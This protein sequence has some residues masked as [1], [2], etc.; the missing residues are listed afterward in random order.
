MHTDTRKAASGIHRMPGLS[1]VAA[2][3]AAWTAPAAGQE[4]LAKKVQEMQAQ[5][6]EMKTRLDDMQQKKVSQEEVLKLMEK[7]SADSAKRASNLPKW[8]ENLKIYGDLRLRC[9]TQTY[10]WGN[11]AREDDLKSRNRA[12]FRLRV[13]ATKTWL[14]DQLEV[15]FRLASGNN[16]DPTATNQTLGESGTGEPAFAKRPVWIDLA[17]GKYAPNWAKGLSVTGGKMNNPLLLNE[18][19]MDTDI[20]PEGF[21]AEYKVPGL[22]PVEP[23]VGGGYFIL[24]EVGQTTGSVPAFDTTMWAYQGGVSWKIMEDLKYTVSATYMDYDY[25]DLTGLPTRGNDV[26]TNVHNF[27]VVN[28][29]NKVDFNVWKVPVCLFFDWAHNADDED[30]TSDYRNADDAYATGVQ[31]GQNKKQGDLSCK[32]RYFQVQGNSLPGYLVDGD[33]GQANHQG[34]IWGVQYNLTDDLTLGLALFYFSPIFPSVTNASGRLT[35]DTTTTVR[36]ELIWKF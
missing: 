10:N 28:L 17:Y 20:S 15:G 21:W 26:L 9:E 32:Y 30:R 22:G 23:F 1:L 31:V 25:Y 13:G 5:L 27:H 36:A 34:H 4:D 33:Y 6:A 35:E 19:F 3:V 2:L 7:W 18:I 14:D 24:R 29:G 12:R 8:A 16:N 11:T